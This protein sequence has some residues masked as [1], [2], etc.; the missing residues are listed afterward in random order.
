MH[1]TTSSAEERLSVGDIELE[2]IRRGAGR[3][4]LLLHGMQNVDPRA[5]FLDLLGGRAAIIAPSH[6]GF[7]HSPRPADF[8]T[9]YDLVHLYLDV[10]ETLPYERVTLVGLSFGGWLAAEIA[11]QVLPP[12]RPA[13]PRGR[14][15]HQD[16]RSRDARHPGRLQHLAP[17]GAAAELARS[18][19]VGAGLQRHVGRRAGGPRP[20][21]GGAV[22][23]RLA[24]LHVQPPAEALAAPH[25]ACRRSCSGARATGSCSRPTDGPTAP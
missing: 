18:R 5:R 15:R 21:L 4:V 14:V 7:G 24:S 9:V 10:L 11:V 22:P 19:Q 1:A 16:Q 8:D 17:G 23:L 13:R 20:Q 3:P 2:V 12:H 6:P 25:H